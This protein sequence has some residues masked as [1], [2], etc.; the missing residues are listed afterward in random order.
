MTQSRPSS[1]GPPQGATAKNRRWCKICSNHIRIV[2][3]AEKRFP[4]ACLWNWCNKSNSSLNLIS[5]N[6]G[7]KSNS[8]SRSRPCGGGVHLPG[9]IRH[10]CYFVSNGSGRLPVKCVHCG[11]SGNRA[12]REGRGLG[13]RSRGRKIRFLGLAPQICIAKVP[14]WIVDVDPNKQNERHYAKPTTTAEATTVRPGRSCSD[15]Q[16]FHSR[17]GLGCLLG[18]RH[19]AHRAADRCLRKGPSQISGVRSSARLHVSTSTIHFIALVA[20]LKTRS[21]FFTHEKNIQD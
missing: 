17:N 7:Y 1:T 20:E 4:L 15:R 10:R 9:Q 19:R 14:D 6:G 8:Q 5:T 18:P 12:I 2:R 21:L 16:S 13:C 3:Q 11:R